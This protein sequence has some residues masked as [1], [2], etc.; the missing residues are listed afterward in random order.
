MQ[1]FIQKNV[2]SRVLGGNGKI[3]PPWIVKLFIHV[4]FLRRLPAGLIGI[5][6]RPERVTSP[7]RWDLNTANHPN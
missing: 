3:E 4:P 6:V 1:V 2:I 5:G 7:E